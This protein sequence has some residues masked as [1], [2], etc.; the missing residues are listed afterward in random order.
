ML[1]T[2]R[3]HTHTRCFCFAHRDAYPVAV[4][5]KHSENAEHDANQ[6]ER[7]SGPIGNA[8]IGNLDALVANC[9]SVCAIEAR[10]NRANWRKR[11]PNLKHQK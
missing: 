9:C 5:Y 11:N 2:P 6:L 7:L 10:S 4:G 1:T 3:T 8:A